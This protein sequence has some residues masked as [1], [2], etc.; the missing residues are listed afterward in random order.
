MKQEVK[1]HRKAEVLS[2]GPRTGK[3]GKSIH[4]MQRI[5]RYNSVTRLASTPGHP[6][7]VIN[8]HGIIV[9]VVDI[10]IRFHGRT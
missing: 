9:P 10:P 3:R 8:L 6:E 7:G 5:K 2:S 4:K 1:K